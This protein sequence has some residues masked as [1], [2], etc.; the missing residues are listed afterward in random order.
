MRIE[1]WDLK[2]FSPALFDFLTPLSIN[3]LYSMILRSLSYDLFTDIFLLHLSN[4]AGGK[5]Y[6]GLAI[7]EVGGN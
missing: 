3:K 5:V 7:L 4:L 6:E 2:N 1:N